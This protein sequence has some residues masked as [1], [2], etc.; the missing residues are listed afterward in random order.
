[1][2]SSFL[3][4]FGKKLGNVTASFFAVGDTNPCLVV[5]PKNIFTMAFAAHPSFNCGLYW[6][7]HHIGISDVLAKANVLSEILYCIS[8]F[9]EAMM[10]EFDMV[11]G[12]IPAMIFGVSGQYS[13]EA[14]W[15]KMMLF[16]FQID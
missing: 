4:A 10:S 3:Y 13:P 5:I 12:N 15:R 14:Q 7:F 1:M 11:K 6:I 8:P 9:F 16:T 2:R